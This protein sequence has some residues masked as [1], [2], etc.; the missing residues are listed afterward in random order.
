MNADARAIWFVSDVHLVQGDRPYLEQFLAF[1]DRALAE[2]DELWIV[3]DLFEFWIGE[4]QTRDGFYDDLFA[5]LAE[6]GRS[7]GPVHVVHGN[8]DFLMGEEFRR[9]GCRLEPDRNRLELGGLD[10]HVSHGDELCVDDLSYQ[11]ARVV[12]RSRPA[13]FVAALL[14]GALGG[15]LA[16][17]YRRISERKKARKKAVT[18]NRFHTIERGLEELAARIDPDVVICGHIHFPADQVLEFA[19]RSRRIITT[20]AWEEGPNYIVW[21]AG[22]FELR[23]FDPAAPCPSP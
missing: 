11:R 5:R 17:R 13:R 2:A 1:L 23:R 10:V 3:G 4:R 14:P 6:F 12:M 19:G 22:D 21:R 15:W 8:R 16:R 7:C 20:G 9:A 18:G